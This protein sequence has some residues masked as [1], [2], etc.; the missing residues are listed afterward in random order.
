MC[1]FDLIV[2]YRSTDPFKIQKKDATWLC[3]KNYNAV[4]LWKKE[5]IYQIYTIDIDPKWIELYI[6]HTRFFLSYYNLMYIDTRIDC[7]YI[8]VRIYH[9]CM[10]NKLTNAS[11][12]YLVAINVCF[13]FLGGGEGGSF[14]W[15]KIYH[16]N[17]NSNQK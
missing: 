8:Y 15:K 17:T 11:S 4:R 7:I 5:R 2:E 9:I 16:G 12:F 6:V 13:F 10:K 3:I 1:H 14:I